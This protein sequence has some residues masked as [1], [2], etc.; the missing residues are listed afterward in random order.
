[1][2]CGPVHPVSGLWAMRLSPL[3]TTLRSS[4][5]RAAFPGVWPGG[6]HDERFAG[7]VEDLSLFESGHLYDWHN[8][9]PFAAGQGDGGTVEATPAAT[10]E[11]RS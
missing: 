7:D 4:I 9:C 2:I 10:W 3:I 1:M 6:M 5:S 8:L 11:S